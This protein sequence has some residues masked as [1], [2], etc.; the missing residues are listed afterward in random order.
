[1]GPSE[2]ESMAQLIETIKPDY[3]TLLVEHDM[4]VVFSLADRVSV[5]VYGTLIATGSPD[6]VARRPRS[7]AGL[8]ER[9]GLR[10]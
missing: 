4:D 5:L 8:P 2:T 9:G 7:T 1:M 6:E 10:C 3:A